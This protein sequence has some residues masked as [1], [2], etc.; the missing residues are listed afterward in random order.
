MRFVWYC[1]VLCGLCA[2]EQTTQNSTEHT[3]SITV[4]I[5]RRVLQIVDALHQM[6][7]GTLK[8]EVTQ[9]TMVKGP[10]GLENRIR[11]SILYES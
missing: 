4:S 7:E 2:T 3:I 8:M 10:G 9:G 6:I 11:L 1:E 5:I